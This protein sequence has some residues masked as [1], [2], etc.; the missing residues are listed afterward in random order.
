MEHMPQSIRAVTI[1]AVYQSSPNRGSLSEQSQSRQSI[2]AVT[3]K[4]NTSTNPAHLHFACVA[5]Q[6][7]RK[8]IGEQP[9]QRCHLLAQ[10]YQGMEVIL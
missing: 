9:K 7:G 1:E 3:I 10:R 6:T 8:E 5:I 4:A 2:R